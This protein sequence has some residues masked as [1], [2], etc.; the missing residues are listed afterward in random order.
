LRH[1]DGRAL[2]VRG[3]EVGQQPENRRARSLSYFG[4]RPDRNLIY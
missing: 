2:L 3:R 1:A 4:V